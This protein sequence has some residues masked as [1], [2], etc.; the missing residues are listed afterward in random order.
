SSSIISL[1]SKLASKINKLDIFLLVDIDE[2]PEEI[3]ANELL[4]KTVAKKLP[5]A[6]KSSTQI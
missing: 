1:A 4:K 6:T 3:N 5:E 2:L